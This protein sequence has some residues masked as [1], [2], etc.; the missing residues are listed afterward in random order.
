[1][2][3]DDAWRLR[4]LVGVGDTPAAAIVVPVVIAVPG[5]TDD[6]VVYVVDRA[7]GE[8]CAP[9]SSGDEEMKRAAGSANELILAPIAARLCDEEAQRVAS[10]LPDKP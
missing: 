3:V 5:P 4:G 8:S 1:M 2:E 7:Q 10:S 6:I 9:C